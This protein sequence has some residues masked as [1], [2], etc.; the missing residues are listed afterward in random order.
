[1]A[2]RGQIAKDIITKK[3]KETFGADYLGIY[4]KKVYLQA[5]ENGEMVQI[6]ITMTCPKV[7]VSA[8][9]QTTGGVLD[10]DKML[11]NKQV[12]PTTFSPAEITQEETD[13]IE[14]LLKKL[15]L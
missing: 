12:A 6:A 4:D 11:E 13:T 15:N 2:A 14:A 5:K 10:F 1:M 9:P 7:P 3:L 8:V